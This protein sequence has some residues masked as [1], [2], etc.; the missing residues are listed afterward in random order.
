M[1]YQKKYLGWIAVSVLAVLCVIGWVYAWNR[2]G[3]SM[4]DA[5]YAASFSEFSWNGV[6]YTRLSQEELQENDSEMRTP[7]GIAG[8]R[9]GEIVL[10]T[11]RGTETCT[12]YCTG[13]AGEAGTVYSRT[14]LRTGVGWFAYAGC[15]FASLGDSPS[16]AEVC[17]AFGLTEANQIA[18]VTVTD[19]ADG[20]KAKLTETAELEAFYSK[21]TALGDSISEEE[22]AKAYYDAYVR[23]YGENNGA[24]LEDGKVQF[25]SEDA[26]ERATALWAEGVRL[27][28][29]RLNNGF[30]MRDLVYAPVP[31]LFTVF[32]CYHFDGEILSAEGT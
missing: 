20:S 4:H 23:E 28:T 22:Q 17:S 9:L 10:S 21:L 14:V 30:L 5:E 11:S 27:V 3:K 1:E 18:S 6:D 7:E 25:A 15:G 26:N 24:V 8:D 2:I 32:G 13:N 19:P 16:I 31:Q 12:L 29:V